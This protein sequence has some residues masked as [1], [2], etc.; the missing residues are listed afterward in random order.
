M[1][2][3]VNE[4]SNGSVSDSLTEL[5]LSES[6]NATISVVQGSSVEKLT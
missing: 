2:N 6:G 5:G 3:H 4:L 1:N